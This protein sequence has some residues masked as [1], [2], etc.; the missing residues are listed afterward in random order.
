MPPG[1]VPHHFDNVDIRQDRPLQNNDHHSKPLHL[2]DVEL[3]GYP[4]SIYEEPINEEYVQVQ[5]RLYSYNPS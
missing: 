4:G 1:E 3:Y 2:S 5:R